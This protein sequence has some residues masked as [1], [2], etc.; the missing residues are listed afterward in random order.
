MM[1]PQ[2]DRSEFIIVMECPVKRRIKL[3]LCPLRAAKAGYPGG[4]GSVRAFST[5]IKKTET[6]Q[7]GF[8][9]PYLSVVVFPTGTPSSTGTSG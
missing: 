6:R 9:G 1:A 7:F 3:L 2:G 5:N 8:T 4:Y